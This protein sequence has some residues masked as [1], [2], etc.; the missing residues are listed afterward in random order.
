MERIE[1][2]YEVQLPIL[3]KRIWYLPNHKMR[4]IPGCKLDK[5]SYFTLNDLNFD[6]KIRNQKFEHKVY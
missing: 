5:Y 6:M 1:L 2:I 3:E 4:V